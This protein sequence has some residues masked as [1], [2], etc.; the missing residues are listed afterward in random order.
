M[1]YVLLATLAL[2]FAACS[3]LPD[4]DGPASIERINPPDIYLVNAAGEPLVYLA[5]ERETSHLIDVAP[6]ITFDEIPETYVRPGEEDLVE[7]IDGYER[8]D[9]VTFFLYAIADSTR[10]DTSAAQPITAHFT[11]TR[12]ATHE[13]LLRKDFRVVVDSL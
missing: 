2:A 12:F 5:V 1:R 7:N 3:L 13:E 10:A 11:W 8:G 6:T 4:G 9:D